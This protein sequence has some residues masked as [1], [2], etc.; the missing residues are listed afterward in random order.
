MHSAQ[1]L[2]TLAAVAVCGL[3]LPDDLVD[4]T[5]LAEHLVE[6]ASNVVR[7]APSHVHINRPILR[8]QIP[9]QDQPLVDHRDERIR[10]AP[11]GVAVGDLLEDVGFHVEGIAADL[12]VHREV[13][14]DVERRVDV[15]QLQAAGFLDLLA[16]RAGFQAGRNQLVVAPVQLVRPAAHLPPA[17]V[18][19]LGLQRC[20]RLRPRLVHVLERLER[21]HR[22]A[23]VARLAVPHQLDLALVLEQHEAVLP[24]QRPAGLDRRDQ[25]AL[26]GVGEVDARVR[27][28][29]H[30]S[31][32]GQ[33]PSA[34]ASEQVKV[35]AALRRR[36]SSVTRR[37]PKAPA[38]ATNRAS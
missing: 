4:R 6:F 26:F 21:Q 7:H 18:E 24:G 29:G 34:S 1:V 23:H 27:A 32:V 12:D 37:V 8:Q 28:G 19:Q 20:I 16:Q 14:A 11:P 30:E 36:A 2:R 10:T 3:S 13:G 38:A 33:R 31:G 17:R 15:D 5:L 35:G 9:H 25:V 22:R